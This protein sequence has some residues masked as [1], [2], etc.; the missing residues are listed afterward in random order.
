VQ[1]QN[2]LGPAHFVFR[3]IYL[4]NWNGG[5]SAIAAVIYWP[6]MMDGDDCG[7]ISGMSGWQGKQKYWEQTRSNVALPTTD[8]TWLEL[9][10]N[11]A[12]R[13]LGPPLSSNKL[14]L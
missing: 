4:L 11:L 3:F 1:R 5:K 8:P 9:G 13:R 6:W 12:N 14:T 7:A 10:W 2:E